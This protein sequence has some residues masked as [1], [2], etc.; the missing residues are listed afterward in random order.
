MPLWGGCASKYAREFWA[1]REKWE[2]IEQEQR[3]AAEQKI[4]QLREAATQGDAEAQYQI[5]YEYVRPLPGMP[6]RRYTRKNEDT[7]VQ[8]TGTFKQAVKVSGQHEKQLAIGNVLISTSP[9][10]PFVEFERY[11]VSVVE[12]STFI[13]MEEGRK[14][15]HKSAEQGHIEAQYQL[16]CQ[17]VNMYITH[18]DGTF[19]PL[20]SAE[21]FRWLHRAAEQGHIEAHFQL[22]LSYY[23][24]MGRISNP[25]D[26]AEGIKWLR[27]AMS[28]GHEGAVTALR[29]IEEQM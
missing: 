17:Y 21:G 8:T 29:V 12:N 14:W 9:K 5:G 26:K 24:K 18:E 28:M 22:G 7:W 25:E 23:Y 16:G 3:E 10:L 20:D 1:E 6:M 15:L 11:S 2:K 19:G 13:D 27:R 4:E